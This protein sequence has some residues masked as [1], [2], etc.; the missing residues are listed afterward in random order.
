MQSDIEDDNFSEPLILSVTALSITLL[1]CLSMAQKAW[2]S[3]TRVFPHLPL[4]EGLDS[5]H[6][7]AE[8]VLCMTM[9]VALL[10]VTFSSRKRLFTWIYT[11]AA[12]ISVIFDQTRLQPWFYSFSVMLLIAGSLELNKAKQG[13]S[14]NVL[15][16]LR[17]CI[18]GTYFYAGLQKLNGAFAPDVVM[19]LLQPLKAEITILEAQLIAV[20]AAI[21]ETLLAILLCIPRTAKFGA[22]LGMGFHA[23]ALGLLVQLRWNSV[24][25]P[26]NI[27]MI[28][29]L[30]ILFLRTPPAATFKMFRPDTPAKIAVII[31]FMLLPALNFFGLWDNYLSAAL[32]TGNVP[33]LRV[34]LTPAQVKTLPAPIAAHVDVL[35][36]GK[37]TI[38]IE[39]WAIDELGVPAYPE[40]R[41]HN[42]LAKKTRDKIPQLENAEFVIETFPRF[43]AGQK[44]L[45][46][47]DLSGAKNPRW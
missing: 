7:F 9:T 24:V 11:A 10:S 46:P 22:I 40:I 17:L 15:N 8:P 4:F 44:E 31:L 28:T 13:D 38:F 32:Y 16:A 42:I 5:L 36:Y 3:P 41:W 43:Y 29:L 45:R 19:W 33:N 34:F 14:E 30:Y 39:N 47:I 23:F 20:P 18:I 26:W 1:A 6:N 25:W 21:F 2:I 27:S 35:K 37:P 12:A